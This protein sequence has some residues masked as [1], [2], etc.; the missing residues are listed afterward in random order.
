[1]SVRLA[2]GQSARGVGAELERLLRAAAPAGAEVSME[3]E[4][5]DPALFDPADPALQ[6]A[7]EAM[8]RACGAAPAFVRTG[9]HAA[10]AGRA[11]R[12]AASPR[13]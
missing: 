7:A 10:A 5:A 2:P 4:L 1:M 13:S 3:L 11:G 9:R 6:L 8:E 12:R